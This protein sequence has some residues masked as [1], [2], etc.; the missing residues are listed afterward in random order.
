MISY[1]HVVEVAKPSFSLNCFGGV[2]NDL[3]MR[4]TFPK[5]LEVVIDETPYLV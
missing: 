1:A 3:M 2:W 4:Q 5:V